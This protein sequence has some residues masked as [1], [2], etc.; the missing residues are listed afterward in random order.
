MK[1]EKR[2]QSFISSFELFWKN[3][4][5]NQEKDKEKEIEKS[6]EKIESVV[7]E[8]DII[9]KEGEKNESHKEVIE[10]IESKEKIEGNE[11]EKEKSLKSWPI[12]T[13][14]PSSNLACVVKCWDSSNITQLPNTFSLCH[15]GNQVNEVEF[16]QRV[17]RNNDFWKHD[18]IHESQGKE[19][20][21]SFFNPNEKFSKV[22]VVTFH[23]FFRFIFD[24][25][26]IQATNSRSNSLEEGG[27]D[28]ILI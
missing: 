25:G 18:Y 1:I 15:E 20:K 3:V 2:M 23:E 28:V 12:T 21:T 11:W 22:E 26:G 9:V 6:K 8:N 13:L 7:K 19:K 14:V 24:P 4:F 10:E 16:P 5:K 27:N 17:E